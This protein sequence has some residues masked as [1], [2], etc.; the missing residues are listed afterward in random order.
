MRIIAGEYKGRRI[1]VPAGLR[2]R[3]TTDRVREALFS[4]LG[5]HVVQAVAL[6]LFAGSG[7]L[8][9]EALSRGARSCTFVESDAKVASTLGRNVEG[10]GAQ[11][12]AT[13]LRMPVERALARLG[14]QGARF[15][16]VLLDPPYAEA[17]WE[18]A[19]RSLARCGILAAGSIVVAEHPTR[20]PLPQGIDGPVGL[21]LT[22]DRTYGEVALALYRA[23]PAEE[24]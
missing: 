5:A 4:I 24:A 11:G 1:E 21:A 7:A 9:I 20:S 22:E 17:L 18:P 12:R 23:R 6:D 19:L 8:G 3:P 16:L 15:D 2:T 13:V 10:L 14:G